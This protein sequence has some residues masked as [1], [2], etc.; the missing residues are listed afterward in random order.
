MGTSKVRY[1]HGTSSKHTASIR[2]HGLRPREVHPGLRGIYVTTDEGVAW[3]YAH[4]ADDGTPVVWV[5][6]RLPP[7]CKVI[8]DPEFV[9]PD[10]SEWSEKQ[11]RTSFIIVGCDRLKARMLR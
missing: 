11:R 2:R 3:D 10:D 7:K 5:I 1:Y 9:S 4:L 8:P 6:D